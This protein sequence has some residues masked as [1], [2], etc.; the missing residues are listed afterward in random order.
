MNYEAT[1]L[2]QATSILGLT[3]LLGACTKSEDKPLPAAQ[4]PTH[5]TPCDLNKD[6]CSVDTRWGKMRVTLTP[7]PVP[8][9]KPLT[10]EARFDQASAVN[11]TVDLNG[12][13]MEMGLNTTR[14]KRTDDKALGGELIIPIC[15]TGSMRWRLKVQLTDGEHKESASFEFVA[16]G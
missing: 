7:K 3:L 11:A 6:A 13:S 15:L 10:V 1:I 14:L 4:P 2:K 12:A 5:A 16:P 9:L 8:M